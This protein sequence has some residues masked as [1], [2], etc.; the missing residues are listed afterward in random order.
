MKHPFSALKIRHLIHCRALTDYLRQ[1]EVLQTPGLFVNRAD[2]M[3][4]DVADESK[5]VRCDCTVARLWVLS[6]TAIVQRCASCLPHSQTSISRRTATILCCCEARVTMEALNAGTGP[7]PTEGRAASAYERAALQFHAATVAC[8]IS[9]REIREAL[10][11]GQPIPQR[12]GPHDVA[13]T[14]LAFF[15]SLPTIFMPPAA[16]QVCDVC[17]P[18][19]SAHPKPT[20]PHF[21]NSSCKQSVVFKRPRFMLQTAFC[22]CWNFHVLTLGATQL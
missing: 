2:H 14:L 3:T 16:G 11:A 19:V 12:A 22:A 15:A 18:S 20:G 4:L 5:I 6:M 1:P 10:D 8:C 9:R 13:A 21:T 17:V 7:C